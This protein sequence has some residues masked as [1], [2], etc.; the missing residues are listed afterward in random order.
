MATK[1]QHKFIKKLETKPFKAESANSD[2]QAKCGP[3]SQNMRPA[4]FF[5]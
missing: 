2:P 5:S 1:L 3:Q 4:R